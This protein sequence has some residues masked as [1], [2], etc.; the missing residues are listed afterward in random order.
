MTTDFKIELSLMYK[1]IEAIILASGSPRRKEFLEN[2]GLDFTIV[3]ASIEEQPKPGETAEE[4]VLRMAMEKAGAISRRFPEKWIISGD[5][6]VCLG[7]EILGKP[8]SKEH[9]VNLLMALSGRTHLVRSSYCLCH[10]PKEHCQGRNN[11][12]QSGIYRFFKRDSRG[13]CSHGGTYG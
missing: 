10:L 12:H 4:F 3:V 7:Q 9:A 11:R 6:I 5:T 8:T 1:N 13:L 2:L